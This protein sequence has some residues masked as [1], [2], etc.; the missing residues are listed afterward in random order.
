MRAV[1]NALRKFEGWLIPDVGRG[2]V[3][4][5]R[6]VTNSRTKCSQAP[7]VRVVTN[8]REHLVWGQCRGNW[9]TPL[10]ATDSTHTSDSGVP[11]IFVDSELPLPCFLFESQYQ[12]C[13]R[14][15]RH[16]IQF[17]NLYR[18]SWIHKKDNYFDI[19]CIW[20]C[21]NKKNVLI[22]K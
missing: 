19:F 18:K 1:P 8:S 10:V 22:L 7:C 3:A 16:H 5:V 13:R 11:A 17:R 6:P 12:N 14:Q 21:R 4:D 20:S 2:P 9:W 15:L